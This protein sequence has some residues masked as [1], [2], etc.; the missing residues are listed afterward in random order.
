MC[1]VYIFRVFKYLTHY[2]LFETVITQLYLYKNKN[3]ILAKSYSLIA[4]ET[5][6]LIV[7]DISFSIMIQV[8]FVKIIAQNLILFFHF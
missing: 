3:K 2:K 7:C 5:S 8:F 6:V 1:V 4:N